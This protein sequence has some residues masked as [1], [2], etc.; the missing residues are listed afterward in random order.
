[1]TLRYAGF[2]QFD[3]SLR[4]F[5][6]IEHYAKSC[7]GVTIQAFVTCRPLSISF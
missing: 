2:L 6:R 5:R 3:D 4:F 1:M 7:N